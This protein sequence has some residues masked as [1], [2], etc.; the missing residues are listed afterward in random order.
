MDALELSGQRFGRLVA[1]E[2]SH[3]KTYRNAAGRMTCSIRFWVCACDCGQKATISGSALKSGKTTS[4]G[5]YRARKGKPSPARKE[6]GVGATNV[7]FGRYRTSAR[8]RGLPWCLT[9]LQFYVVGSAACTYCGCDPPM[10]NNYGKNYGAV[11]FNGI[12]RKDP[13]GG[14]SLDNVVPCCA[15][16]NYSKQEMTIEQFKAW[17]H[18]VHALLISHS[19]GDPQ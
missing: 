3:S 9:K 4:C 19:W 1:V 18:K 11:P 10:F 6:A 14:Y 17:I 7:L 5:C 13:A 16:C 15:V 2:Y 8:L 12:D